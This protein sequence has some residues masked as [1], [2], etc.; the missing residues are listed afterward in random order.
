MNEVDITRLDQFRQIKKEIRGSRDYLIAG[1]A[2][3]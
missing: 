1:I 2:Q 3:C